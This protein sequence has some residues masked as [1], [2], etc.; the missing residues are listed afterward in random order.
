MELS[1]MRFPLWCCM[2]HSI[3]PVPFVF[4]PHHRIDIPERE[5]QVI[6]VNDVRW[7]FLRH[8]LVEDRN[9][10]VVRRIRKTCRGLGS[11]FFSFAGRHSAYQS[12]SANSVADTVEAAEFENSV[13]SPLDC[14]FSEAKNAP[15]TP[16]SF[17]FLDA[18]SDS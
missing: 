3:D 16:S 18:V 14:T 6:L 1:G 13:R 5:T 17:Q 4:H 2:S 7:D 12:C 9:R 15:A 10:G 8:D 11:C